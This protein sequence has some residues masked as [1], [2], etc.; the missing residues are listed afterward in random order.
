MIF[1]GQSDTPSKIVDGGVKF[2]KT[3]GL[4][5]QKKAG[6]NLAWTTAPWPAGFFSNP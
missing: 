5:F 6:T 3:G 1:Q 2:P 4:K